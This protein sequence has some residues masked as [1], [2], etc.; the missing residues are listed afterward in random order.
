M[1]V[2]ESTDVNHLLEYLFGRAR[3]TFAASYK[4]TQSEA[5]LAAG[6]L[7][8]RAYD[9]LSAGMTRADV[10]RLWPQAERIRRGS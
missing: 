6:R 7:A 8:Q 9:R 10:E 4:V 3:L 1:N 2:G 5:R